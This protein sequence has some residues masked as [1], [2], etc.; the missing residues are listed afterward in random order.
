MGSW[1]EIA[2]RKLRRKMQN[3]IILTNCMVLDFDFQ[4]C[5]E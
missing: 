4:A 3:E 1:E 2:M 5:E